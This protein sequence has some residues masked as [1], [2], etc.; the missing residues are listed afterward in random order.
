M[1]LFHTHGG[2]ALLFVETQDPEWDVGRLTRGGA[3]WESVKS[4]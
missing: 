4:Q 3:F 2:S 1:H